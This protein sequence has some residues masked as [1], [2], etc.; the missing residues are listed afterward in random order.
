MT[1]AGH[2]T[3]VDINLKMSLF[4]FRLVYSEQ[5]LSLA[6]EPALQSLCPRTRISCQAE[7]LSVCGLEQGLVS[8][9]SLDSF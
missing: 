6:S 3:H 9:V 1:L 4:T 7:V 2:D 5:Q 8:L